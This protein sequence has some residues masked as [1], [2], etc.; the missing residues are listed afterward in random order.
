MVVNVPGAFLTAPIAEES[1]TWWQTN[2]EFLFKLE[3]QQ[4]RACIDNMIRLN[5]TTGSISTEKLCALILIPAAAT[6]PLS[7]TYPCN[8]GL[9]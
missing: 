4:P 8:N 5:P 2:E 3:L 7:N 6:Y 9:Y 1:L